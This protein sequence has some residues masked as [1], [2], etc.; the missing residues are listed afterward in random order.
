M[1]FSV[2]VPTYN[3]AEFLK[4][5]IDSVLNQSFNDFE[6]IIINDGSTDNTKQILDFYAA[7]IR[8]FNNEKSGAEKCRNLGADMAKGQYFVFLD[9]DDLFFSWT[10]QVYDQIIKKN[11]DL[12]F[13]MGQP[14]HFS[15]KIDIK[16]VIKPDKISVATYKDYFSKDRPVYS[17]CSMLVIQKDYF[18]KVGGFR[19]DYTYKD[20]FLDDIDFLLRAGTIGPLAIVY[21]PF[22]FAYRSHTENSVKNLN[23]ILRSLYYMV[24]EDKRGLF[25]GGKERKFERYAIMGGPIYFWALKALRN[26]IVWDSIKLLIKTLP[27]ISSGLLKK[28]RNIFISKEKLETLFF[29]D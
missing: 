13:L 11:W 25:A 3:R 12:P 19:S 29:N 18:F 7:K 17:S 27:M 23:R 10:L 28:I 24:L 5:T 4:E 2:I 26:G 6:L 15:K 20:Y 14:F 8:S 9:D 1:Q 21:E 22:Q 16:S